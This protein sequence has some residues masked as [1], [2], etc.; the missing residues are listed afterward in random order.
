VRRG[1]PSGSRRAAHVSVPTTGPGDA[2]YAHRTPVSVS[3]AASRRAGSG[4]LG[5][6]SCVGSVRRNPLKAPV[7]PTGAPSCHEVQPGEPRRFAFPANPVCT[8]GRA[9][10][11]RD[12]AHAN[13]GES[14]RS[15]RLPVIEPA[16]RPIPPAG[17]LQ[18]LAVCNGHSIAFSRD[19][20]DAAPT[21]PAS[22]SSGRSSDV[23]P[24]F[25]LL[26]TR[27]H[28]VRR[29]PG[30]VSRAVAARP[31]FAQGG[32]RLLWRGVLAAVPPG[33][34]E[35]VVAGSNRPSAQR[36]IPLGGELVRRGECATDRDRQGRSASRL[37]RAP[38][39]PRTA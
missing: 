15:R 6:S 21:A 5:L 27:R 14:H 20:A 1:A 16:R 25:A 38:R 18:P 23:P 29:R 33:A 9:P 39:Y 8:A 10:A 19:R 22:A 32:R 24:N 31:C 3:N 13:G 7:R 12:I 11:S 17:R 35:G 34:V 30:P 2:A 28:R 36:R 26:H 4:H 37:A